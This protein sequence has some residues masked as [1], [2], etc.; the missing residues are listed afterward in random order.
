MGTKLW[1]RRMNRQLKATSLLTKCCS[2]F[3]QVRSMKLPSNQTGM[4]WMI[5]D[6]FGC[7]SKTATLLPCVIRKKSFLPKKE[8]AMPKPDI[9]YD[10]FHGANQSLAQ[11]DSQSSSC[12]K[13]LSPSAS[14]S[15]SSAILY[16]SSEDTQTYGAT[17]LT[18][19]PTGE[20]SWEE[21]VTP[22][23]EFVTRSVSFREESTTPITRRVL[24]TDLPLV[25]DRLDVRGEQWH[26]PQTRPLFNSHGQ[27]DSYRQN[28]SNYRSGCTHP[29]PT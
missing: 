22:S 12:S 27:H 14:R 17:A 9:D 2:L 15:C 4:H 24:L 10:L 8:E 11:S 5:T 26:A 29:L 6:N 7:D 1:R 23:E 3:S 18:T 16:S 20:K 21:E 19:N 25:K 28:L 13:H